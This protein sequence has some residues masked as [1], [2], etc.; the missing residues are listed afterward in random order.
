MSVWE[1]IEAKCFVIIFLH[2]LVHLL[3]SNASFDVLSMLL[4]QRKLL[5]DLNLVELF[6]LVFDPLILKPLL[7]NI[8][9]SLLSLIQCIGLRLLHILFHVHASILTRRFVREKSALASID[10]LLEKV[11]KRDLWKELIVFK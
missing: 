10:L 4:L 8:N 11:F 7:L 9:D 5:F 2:L 3:L 1:V 6:H